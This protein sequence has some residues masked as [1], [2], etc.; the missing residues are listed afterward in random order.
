MLARFFGTGRFAA[1]A[2]ALLATWEAFLVVVAF[3]PA[4]P[5]ALAAFA[6]E[7]RVW[8]LGA[9]PATGRMTLGSVGPV[10]AEAPLLGLLIA[11]LWWRSL[12]V[13][14]RRAGARWGAAGVGVVL[15]AGVVVAALAPARAAELPFPKDGLRT[16]LPAPRFRLVDQDGA[17]LGL[18]DLRGRVVLVTAIYSRCGAT[19]PMILAE[20]RRLVATLAPADRARMSIVG[21]TLDP[22]H[23]DPATLAAVAASQGLS[24]PLVRLLSGPP[25][26]VEA[27]LDALQVAR[28]RDPDTGAIEHANLFILVDA[29]GR[30]A[31]RLAPGAAQEKWL[32]AALDALLPEAAP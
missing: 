12:A 32:R 19:C 30:I 15:A 31:Y 20:I 21:I 9:D 16:A 18:E 26:E 14:G 2:L 5:G 8:C 1:F 23:D 17:R 10:L 6:Q 7:F 28:R 24:A 3:V 27:A 13:L 25:A 11:A 22:G 29:G 4:P